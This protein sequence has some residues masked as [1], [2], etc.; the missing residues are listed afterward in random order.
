MIGPACGLPSAD[1]MPPRRLKPAFILETQGAAGSRALSKREKG[2]SARKKS[3]Q[4]ERNPFEA[5]KK[6]FQSKSKVGSKQERNV[7]ARSSVRTSYITESA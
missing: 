1:S 4:Q 5:R 3:F 6:S 2:L 7:L